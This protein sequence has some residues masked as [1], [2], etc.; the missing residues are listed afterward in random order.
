MASFLETRF[1]FFLLTS[2]RPTQTRSG[3]VFRGEASSHAPTEL[4]RANNLEIRQAA[5]SNQT[6]G[7]RREDRP[8]AY[9]TNGDKQISPERNG[10]FDPELNEKPS[11]RCLSPFPTR[12]AGSFARRWRTNANCTDAQRR[13]RR[14][15]RAGSRTR[16]DPVRLCADAS[17]GRPPHGSGIFPGASPGISPASL[18][19]LSGIF[20]A[21]FPHFLRHLLHHLFAL[22]RMIRASPAPVPAG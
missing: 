4:I 16:L 14:L 3:F 22:P 8:N 18:R 6:A 10:A 12:S 19:H 20:P 15:C 11:N 9:Q 21:S 2:S 5:K 13:L 7:L 1:Y 17:A